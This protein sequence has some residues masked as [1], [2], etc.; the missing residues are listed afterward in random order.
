MLPHPQLHILLLLLLTWFIGRTELVSDCQMS[1]IYMHRNMSQ[2]PRY[3]PYT[4][5]TAN[6]SDRSLFVSGRVG[7]CPYIR[8]TR[9][10]HH[11]I[12]GGKYTSNGKDQRMKN[13]QLRLSNRR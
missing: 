8:A 11:S 2:Q 10:P 5:R 12:T 3:Q 9:N 7:K 13:K 4:P 6:L 1:G